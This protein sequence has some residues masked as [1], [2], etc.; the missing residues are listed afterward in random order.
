[1]QSQSD[2]ELLAFLRTGR[3]ADDPGNQSGIAMPPSGGRPDLTDRDLLAIIYYLRTELMT[4]AA[5]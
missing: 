5:P 3:A 1:V 2:A 4:P